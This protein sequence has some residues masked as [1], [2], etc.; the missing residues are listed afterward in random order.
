MTDARKEAAETIFSR[1]FQ[2]CPVDITDEV[3]ALRVLIAALSERKGVE[4]EIAVD[5]EGMVEESN[6]WLVQH[7]VDF[8]DDGDWLIPVIQKHLKPKECGWTWIGGKL[9]PPLVSGT[10]H[11]RLD[12]QPVESPQGYCRGCGGRIVEKDEE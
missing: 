2:K 11:A 6:R 5:V 12:I 10:A 9:Y 4:V 7:G 1:L 3:H 8:D